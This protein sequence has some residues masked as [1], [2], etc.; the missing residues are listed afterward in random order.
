M[1]FCVPLDTDTTCPTP[2]TVDNIV[3]SP[4]KNTYS[5]GDQVEYVCPTSSSNDVR[6]RTC[7]SS[8]T[9]TDLGFVCG[10]CPEGWGMV[11]G[12][13][14]KWFDKYLTRDDAK[15]FCEGLG[16]GLAVIT[17]QKQH[18]YVYRIVLID[19]EEMQEAWIALKRIDGQY[20]WDDGTEVTF[21]GW[22]SGNQLLHSDV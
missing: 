20:K 2:G 15:T 17:S 8:G 11:D 3:P 1:I 4:A 6:T 10:A 22:K 9:W 13:C 7:T 19:A 18:D 14:Y 12:R 5:V 16:A 21:D